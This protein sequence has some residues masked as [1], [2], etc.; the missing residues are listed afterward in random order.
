MELAELIDHIRAYTPSCEQEV[1]DREQ[2]LQIMRNSTN[3][4]SRENTVAHFTVSAWTVNPERS[5]TLLVYHNIYDSWSWVGGHSDGE[6]DL[7]SVAK[8]ELE[9]E[10]GI[11]H[12]RLAREG[13]FS[14]EALPVAGHVRRGIYVSSHVH[15]NLTYLFEADETE[16]LRANNLEN[17][18]VRWFTLSDALAVSTEPWMVEHVYKKL[19]RMT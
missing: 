19:V 9:E 13:I 10:T 5:K 16:A 17:Q 18:A 8:R 4:L 1:R 14:L 11:H 15:L 6:A 12:A 2:M 7:C 3:C